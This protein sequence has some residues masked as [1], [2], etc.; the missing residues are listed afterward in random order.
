MLKWLITNTPADMTDRLWSR[1]YHSIPLSSWHLSRLCLH[2][3]TPTNRT[4]TAC[5]PIK[6]KDCKSVGPHC[7]SNRGTTPFS[8][9]SLIFLLFFV[10]VCFEDSLYRWNISCYFYCILPTACTAWCMYIFIKFELALEMNISK[11][12]LGFKVFAR[13]R[14]DYS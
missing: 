11:K 2:D 9:S 5:L 13:T 1:T 8:R 6:C 3:Q 10:F 7:E 14:A 4:M 12:N